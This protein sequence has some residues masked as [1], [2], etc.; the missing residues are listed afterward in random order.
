M[1]RALRWPAIAAVTALTCGMTAGASQA[2]EK[3]A[4]APAAGPGT[5]TS[6]PVVSRSLVSASGRSLSAA[7]A[8]QAAATDLVYRVPQGGTIQVQEPPAGFSAA[9]ASKAELSSLGLRSAAVRPLLRLI[10][11][12]GMR[13]VPVGSLC[14]LTGLSYAPPAT[15]NPNDS[16]NWAGPVV[17]A[18]GAHRHFFEAAASFAEPHFVPGCPGK[19]DHAIWT[20]LGGYVGSRA[21][22]QDGTDTV[23]G[24]GG[25]NHAFAWLELIATHSANPPL[26]L[27]PKTFPV[28]VGNKM[29][30]LAQYKNDK[31]VFDYVNSTKKIYAQLTITGAYGHHPS[32]FYDGASAEVIN[33]RGFTG[34][35]FLKYREPVG[36]RV[37]FSAASFNNGQSAH[38]D[39]RYLHVLTMTRDGAKGG[40]VLDRVGS[41]KSTLHSS[42]W[43]DQWYRCN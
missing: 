25:P 31:I 23:V 26:E 21:L 15:A 11:A 1:K 35:G 38:A 9:T 7:S 20:G 30:V 4:A 17:S 42:S 14:Q 10:S 5:C 12:P 33:E 39:K 32:Y 36:K 24:G 27:N 3:G 40:P 18:K 34:K 43:H 41:L 16:F 13:Y 6:V 37:T 28:G 19:S 29:T 22:L 8:R 2:A